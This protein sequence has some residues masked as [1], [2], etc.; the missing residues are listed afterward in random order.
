MRRSQSLPCDLDSYSNINIEDLNYINELQE[1]I[2]D[3]LIENAK[4]A[5]LICTLTNNLNSKTQLLQLSTTNYNTIQ[6]IKKHRVNKS[7][8]K[9]QKMDFYKK[10]KN[11]QQVND[12]LHLKYKNTLLELDIPIPWQIVKAITDDLFLKQSK[13]V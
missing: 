11:S 2:N 13:H 7:S 5:E 3:L 1:K 10:N 8:V 12:I 9:Q 6:N 4:Q